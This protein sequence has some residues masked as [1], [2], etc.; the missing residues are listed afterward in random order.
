MITTIAATPTNQ[1]VGITP[2]KLGGL[3]YRTRTYTTRTKTW[4]A[5]IALIPIRRALGDALL[6][7]TNTSKA[8]PKEISSYVS[9]VGFEP[10]GC[11]SHD[12][13]RDRDYSNQY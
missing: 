1:L 5:A 8:I 9:L 6:F 2:P 11:H 3:G 4:C 13:L 10:T 12:Q 7:T